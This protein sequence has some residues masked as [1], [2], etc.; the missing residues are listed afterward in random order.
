MF[1]VYQKGSDKKCKVFAVKEVNGVIYFLM[2]SSTTKW[3]W[4]L[5]KNYYPKMN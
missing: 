2:Y 1:T 3:S 5:A 4:E